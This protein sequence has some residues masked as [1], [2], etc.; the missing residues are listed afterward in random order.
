MGYGFLKRA[1]L[2]GLTLLCVGLIP[3]TAEAQ[4]TVGVPNFDQLYAS[5]PK[6]DVYPSYMQGSGLLHVKETQQPAYEVFSTTGYTPN[7]PTAAIVDP[8]ITKMQIE[9]D[10]PG[11]TY[12]GIF[13]L[14]DGQPFSIVK[15]MFSGEYWLHGVVNGQYRAAVCGGYDKQSGLVSSCKKAQTR[16]H[17]EQVVNAVN[18]AAKM[19]EKYIETATEMKGFAP[20][21]TQNPGE[22]AEYIARQRRN[23]EQLK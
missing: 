7:G 5:K 1:F 19:A 9:S 21:P 17:K 10:L 12:F 20:S 13:Q 3:L 18:I 14:I 16:I 4:G 11:A 8:S 2:T 23:Y 6:L 22:K 15:D